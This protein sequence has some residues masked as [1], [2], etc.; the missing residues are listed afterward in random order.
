MVPL[1]V[2]IEIKR[3]STPTKCFS[4]LLALHYKT[5]YVHP[6]PINYFAHYRENKINKEDTFMFYYLFAKSKL[7]QMF[8][9]GD[10]FE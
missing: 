7:L 9:S 3:F 8:S 2:E 4:T 6:K 1:C 10:A 5:F